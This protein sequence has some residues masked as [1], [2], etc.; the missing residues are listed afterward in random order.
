MKMT[1]NRL[2]LKLVSNLS[3]LLALSL[4]CMIGCGRNQNKLSYWT[5]LTPKADSLV[6]LLQIR[7]DDGT[8]VRGDSIIVRQLMDEAYR[9]RNDQVLARALY[10]KVITAQYDRVMLQGQEKILQRALALT[11]SATFPYDAARILTDMPMMQ[12]LMTSRLGDAISSGEVFLA[13]GDYPRY[14][15]TLMQRAEE[16]NSL[17]DTVVGAVMSA[18]AEE[19]FRKTDNKWGQLYS[20]MV[21][22]RNLHLDFLNERACEV[23]DSA[24]RIQGFRTTPYYIAI[25]D[26]IRFTKSDNIA[27]AY[28]GRDLSEQPTMVPW[29]KPY[30]YIL[31][32]DWHRRHGDLDSMSYYMRRHE[33]TLGGISR[34]YPDI[35]DKS[36]LIYLAENKP[37][38]VAKVDANIHMLKE[39]V[40]NVKITAKG[41]NVRYEAELKAADKAL[42]DLQR[43][44]FTIITLIVIGSVTFLLIVV[45]ILHRRQ[46]RCRKAL[47]A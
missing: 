1:L 45:W 43:S 22:A 18:K 40:K 39:V 42:R 34:A 11:D 47:D 8:L 21:R 9:S 28:E 38:S 44:S 4:M 37:D 6:N 24:E 32:A 5:P 19:I 7:Q 23:L 3:Y 46:L 14:A 27:Y 13:A 12:K 33:A 25:R 10:W 20:L 41:Q 30:F 15:Y 31:I 29:L 35:F 16:L 26:V 2:F 17:G 36:R